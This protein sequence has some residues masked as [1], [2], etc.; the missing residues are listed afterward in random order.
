MKK[1]IIILLPNLLSEFSEDLLAKPSVEEA[2]SMMAQ[3]SNDD[4]FP[5]N[6]KAE[7]ETLDG[8]IAESRKSAIRYLLRF[9]SR[10]RA[11]SLPILLLNEHTGE[12][13]M[14]EL[15]SR[16]KAEGGRWG[17]ISDAGLPCLADPGSNVVAFANENGFQVKV[18]FGPCSIILA[19]MLSGLDG[20]NFSFHGYLPRKEEDL[21]PFIRKLEKRSS[22]EGSAEIFIEAPYRSDKLLSLLITT[23]RDDVRLCVAKDLTMASQAVFSYEVKKWKQLKITLGK[24]PCVFLFSSKSLKKPLK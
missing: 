11:N 13:E 19:L 14:K 16:I 21:I 2:V 1:P 4:L 10:E 23:L 8:L 20:Q 24:S 7:V 12:E 5:K 6:L 9:V 18:L 3:S 22:D 17:L 15:L